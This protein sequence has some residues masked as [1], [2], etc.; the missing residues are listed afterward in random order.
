MGLSKGASFMRYLVNLA[1]VNSSD[2]GMVGGK[3]ASL[4]EMIQHLKPK[5]IKVPG[6]FATTTDL[7]K[8]FLAQQGLDKKISHALSSLDINDIDALEK[9]AKRIRRWIITTPFPK[10][11]ENE[12]AKAYA[13][14][15]NA[16]VAVRSSATAED[17][18]TA[19]FAGQQETFLHIKGLKNVLQAIKMV[20]ASLFNDRTIAYRYHQGFDLHQLAISAGIQPMVRSD[21]GVSGVL[22][23]MDTESGFDQV[24][25]ITASYGLGEAIVQGCV[26]PDEF[27]ISKPLLETNKSS[28]LQR[29]LG[30][31][32]VKM[33]YTDTKN[34]RASIK[35]ISV[36][37]KDRLRF[38][39]TDKE[40]L[41]LAQQA[42]IIEKHYGN[43][44]DIEWAKDGLSG[45]LY[46]LQARCETV[47]SREKPE[48]AIEHYHLSAKG[49]IIVEGQSIGQRIGSGLAHVILNPKKMH[50]F[51]SGEI[52]ITDMTDP[53][54]EPIMKRA[55]AIVTNRGGRTCHA[56]II[57]RELGIP[58]IVGC[59]DAT[60]RIKNREAI[61]VSCAEGQDGYVYAGIIPYKVE[62]ISIKTLPKLPLKLCI[63]LGNPEK[64][65]A[66]QA[67]PNDGVG[68]ARLEF[69]INNMIGVHPSALLHFK[70]LPK[71]LQQQI[72]KKTAAYKDPVE[73]YIEKLREGISIIAAAFHPKQVIFRFSDFKSNEYANLLGGNLYEPQEENPMIGYRGASRYN[74]KNFRGCFELECKAFK[75]VRNE[76]GLTNA[77]VMVPFVRTVT[78]LKQVIELIESYG[79]KRG[80]NDLKI[81]MMC[82]IPSNVLLAAEF[83]KY[84]DGF[85]IGSNDL[86]QL[87]LG[88][89]RDSSLVA[90][91][92]DERNEAIKILLHR[93]IKECL[94]QGKYIGICGQ[95]P[96]DHPSFAAWLMHEGIQNIS[97]NPDTIV[98]TWLMLA[99]KL[100]TVKCTSE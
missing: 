84:V 26:N 92:F 59:G 34:P 94:K 83:L 17:L 42:L 12:V 21:K 91:L 19:S 65:F 30:S 20:F 9:T 47:K 16:S 85:S 8:E 37:E 13:N 43:P 52:L 23:T 4:G 48:H 57:A 79:L 58:A 31:K 95:G 35:T 49:K 75:R 77:Q 3:N 50:D 76:M 60:K 96:S 15:K 44:M 64:A 14:L 62:K 55:A 7:Y 38:C 70:S 46:I 32:A 82:E 1:S 18:A 22:F 41:T 74:D 72:S 63:N 45:E 69:I 54:W 98:G 11:F 88:L 67:L 27:C 87:T 90:S 53:D 39:L 24:I 89:D 40:I 66:S 73:F 93:A 80:K 29:R 99:K 61:T 33:V 5:G 78:E 56:A 68:L 97:L 36:S 2:V 71:K 51:K 10:E 86:T 81:Y 100:T 6:G 25:L 28:I